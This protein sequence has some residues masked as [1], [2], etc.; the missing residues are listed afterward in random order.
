[1]LLK[2]LSIFFQKM[3]RF[4][5]AQT[6]QASLGFGHKKNLPASLKGFWS[7]WQDSNLRPPAPKAGAITGLRY[8]P[9]SVCKYSTNI[10]LS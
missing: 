6:F 3:R 9:K 7:G 1:M 8:T 4:F 5:L 10:E 2:N